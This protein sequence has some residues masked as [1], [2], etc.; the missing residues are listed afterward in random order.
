MTTDH[1]TLRWGPIL[2][3]GVAA[4]ILSLLLVFLN[5]RHR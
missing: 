2:Q 5:I 3:A 4:A 1:S